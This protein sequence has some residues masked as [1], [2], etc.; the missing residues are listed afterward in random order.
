[1]L[2]V[3]SSLVVYPAAAVPARAV[4]AGAHLAIVNATETPLDELATLV[5]R[6]RAAEMLP[7]IV[8]AALGPV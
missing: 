4:D 7:P 1:M 5:V 6:G 3:G 8:R 2:V